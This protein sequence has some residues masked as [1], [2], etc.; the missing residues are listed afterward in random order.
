[1][2]RVDRG[3]HEQ[4][5]VGLGQSGVSRRLHQAD[6][7]R[8][9]VHLADHEAERRERLGFVPRLDRRGFLR[10][11]GA[12]ARDQPQPEARRQRLEQRRVGLADLLDGESLQHFGLRLPERDGER[13]LAELER[14]ERR[15]GRR[16]LPLEYGLGLLVDVDEPAVEKEPMVAA[17]VGAAAAVDELVE[18]ERELPLLALS[19]DDQPAEAPLGLFKQRVEALVGDARREVAK[20]VRGRLEPGEQLVDLRGDFRSGRR[21]GR[22]RIGG[23]RRGRQRKG[24]EEAGEHHGREKEEAEGAAF[25]AG[26]GE[27]ET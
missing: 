18:E 7:H 22:R 6:R 24:S 9:A 14:I 15:A 17:A 19:L 21:G 2:R 3:L 1:L 12:L 10:E 4:G 8:V 20:V 13:P 5:A 11:I 27:I 25:R 26:A 16:D 23:R